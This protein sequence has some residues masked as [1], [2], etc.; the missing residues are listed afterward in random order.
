MLSKTNFPICVI[1]LCKSTV[2]E[3]NVIEVNVAILW[4]EER[5]VGK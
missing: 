5:A 3:K 4:G 1:L 2:M